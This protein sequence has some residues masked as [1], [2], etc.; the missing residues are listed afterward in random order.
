MKAKDLPIYDDPFE[1][2]EVC[3]VPN[4]P[5]Q[6]TETVSDV[7]K[8]VFSAAAVTKKYLDVVNDKVSIGKAHTSNTL[9]YIQND[10][11]SLPRAGVI[12]IAGLGGIVAGYRRGFFRKGVYAGL[13][14][15]A[16]AA[17]CYPNQAL[18]IANTA[19]TRARTEATDLWN[20][21]TKTK[22]MSKATLEK[23]IGSPVTEKKTD[24]AVDIGQ[25]NVEDK[26]MYTTRS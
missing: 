15:T 17:I 21:Q 8:S 24:I 12:T 1:G 26:D 5:T 18:D 10:P 22:D 7:R 3:I 25:S 6:F 19:Y 2:K 13:A 16:A 11:G 4:P 23:E 20:S 14:M 9:Q